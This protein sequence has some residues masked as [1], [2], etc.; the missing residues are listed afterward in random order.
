[1]TLCAQCTE[2]HMFQSCFL[3]VLAYAVCV[4]CD[5]TGCSARREF[6][7]LKVV[8]EEEVQP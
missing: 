6:L 3:S 4:L 5:E 1:M 2:S 7:C 8:L